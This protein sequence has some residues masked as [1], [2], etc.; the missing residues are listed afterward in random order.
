MSLGTHRITGAQN[1]ALQN[2]FIKIIKSVQQYLYKS[3]LHKETILFQCSAFHY[4]TIKLKLIMQLF[5][6]SKWH[7]YLVGDDLLSVLTTINCVKEDS[8]S[9]ELLSWLGGGKVS[10]AYT[11]SLSDISVR[12]WSSQYRLLKPSSNI[13]HSTIWNQ[14]QTE[15]INENNTV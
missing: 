9:S 5:N 11:G 8:N 4:M 15:S 13:W 2:Q 10:M 1:R 7:Y 12:G 6:S 14:N 3:N